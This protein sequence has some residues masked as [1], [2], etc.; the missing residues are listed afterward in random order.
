MATLR[1]NQKMTSNKK[2]WHFNLIY[3]VLVCWIGSCIYTYYDSKDKS[4]KFEKKL[5]TLRG[6]NYKELIK[7][8]GEPDEFI[9]NEE[10]TGGKIIIYEQ[11]D[12]ELEMGRVFEERHGIAFWIDDRENMY[13]WEDW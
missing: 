6:Q 8:L 13:R 5:T 2:K 7:E 9:E 3:V 12:Y 10:F 4:E 1:G 11:V